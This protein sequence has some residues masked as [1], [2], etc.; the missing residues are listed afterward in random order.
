MSPTLTSSVHPDGKADLI[1]DFDGIAGRYD[2][3]TRMNPGH[4]THLGWSAER[5]RLSPKAR[6]LERLAT[7]HRVLV[8]RSAATRLISAAC[9]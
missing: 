5:L 2:L 4:L 8:S 6:I 7:R 9:R 3:I 1:D